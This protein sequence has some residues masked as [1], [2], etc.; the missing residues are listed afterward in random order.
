M[1]YKLNLYMD[2]G[3]TVVCVACHKHTA[4]TPLNG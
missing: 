2:S 3:I 4:Y 1:I